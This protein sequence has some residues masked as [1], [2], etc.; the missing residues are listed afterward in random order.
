MA[1][2]RRERQLRRLAGLALEIGAARQLQQVAIAGLALRQQHQLV[3]RRLVADAAAAVEAAALLLAG[4]AELAADDRLQAGVAGGERELE[5]AEEIA[6]VGH[7]DRRHG[8]RL[9]ERDQ[10]LQLDRALGERIGGVDA[11]MDEIGV[12]HAAGFHRVGRES[13]LVIRFRRAA[14]AISGW[15][16]TPRARPWSPVPPR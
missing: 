7:G 1:V 9:A 11:E 2:E 8:L 6:G 15:R 14:T 16:Y 3:G 4:D 13:A 12:R 5:G 10:L